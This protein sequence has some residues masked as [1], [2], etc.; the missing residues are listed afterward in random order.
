MAQIISTDN[1]LKRSVYQMPP[2]QISYGAKD[3]P[4]GIEN[5]DAGIMISNNDTGKLRK[6]RAAKKLNYD[7][8]NGY[9]DETDIEF[10]F[11]P[12]GLKGVKFP[13]K[14]QNYPIEIG[15]FNVLKG[16]ESRRRFDYRLRV[17]NDDA[18][19]ERETGMSEQILQLLYEQ[20]ANPN[21]N[22]QQANRR[23]KNLKKYQ[24]FEY[25]DMREK[26]GTRVL[27]YFWHTRFMKKMLND[28]FWDV[29]I[30]GEEHYSCFKIHGEPEPQR[31]NPLNLSL[32]G[33]GESYKSEDADIMI[34]DGFHPIGKMIDE[35]WDVLKPSES[36]ALEEGSLRNS[37]YANVGLSGPIQVDKEKR[38][39][40]AIIIPVGKDIG[41]YGGYY[42]VDGNIRRTIVIWKSR[43]K[44]GEMTFYV[45]GV[46]NK[47][48]V[49]E[50]KVADES[51]GESIKWHWINEWWW[52][53]KLGNIYLRIEPLPRIG[54]KINNPSICIP[55]I[56]GTIYKINSSESVSLVDRIKPYKYLYNVYMRRTEL[57]SARNKGVLAEM[58][59]AKIP[60][61]WTPEVWALYAEVT[62]YF[63]TDSF[64]EGSR[65]AA[66]GRLVNNLNNRGSSTMDLDSSATIKANLEL[67]IYTKNEL[68]E[69]MGISPQREG[70]M[71]NRETA[72]GIERSVRQSA[73]ITEEWFMV[74]DNTKLRL[75]GLVLE[76]G[77]YCWITQPTK[78][79]QYI[80]DG[81]I[82]H[83]YTIDTKLLA[84]SEYGLFV[85]DGAN[86]SELFSTIRTLAQAAMQNDKARIS[87]ILTIFSDTSISS[88]RRKL[89]ASEEEAFERQQQSEQNKMEM[90]KIT[91]EKKERLEMMK[92]EQIERIEIGKLQNALLL[93]EMDIQGK[94]A[95]AQIKAATDKNE[96]KL[97]LEYRK[98]LDQIAL[99]RD[100]LN[101]RMKEVDKKIS[102]QERIAR[103]NR[104]AKSR[105]T[106]AS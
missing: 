41:A 71:E 101:Q 82:S 53:H 30:A 72:Q 37:S 26:S 97:I 3:E 85:T 102:S 51:K 5:I 29:L 18:I 50:Y 2:Q 78:K 44:V 38:L 67:A 35:Y 83:T 70:S 59:L 81:L 16:E 28:G 45:K 76:T 21:F 22:E 12:L 1:T 63:T 66:T 13:A 42:D 27:N 79:L 33:L 8:I 7:L 91:E 25:Q 75:L 68:G 87:D 39:G 88:M 100:K 86:D 92:M 95:Q 98:Q 23:M 77:K 43:R 69:I 4:W 57:A 84:E 34:I 65:G 36:K 40:D 90:L 24:N 52:G 17:I 74:H 99:E 73:Y 10:A 80:D 6:S 19:S 14:I 58:D 94:L 96:E 11:N 62:G 103:E 60:E 89:E 20:V 49:D 31:I 9:M 55:P 61:G 54:T 56:V 106:T 105:A 15:K 48:W 104:K 32:F 64:K 47:T 46:E 93:K